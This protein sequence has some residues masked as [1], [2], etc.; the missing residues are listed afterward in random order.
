MLVTA[1]HGR[2]YHLQG[3]RQHGNVQVAVNGIRLAV[4]VKE[5]RGCAGDDDLIA[6]IIANVRHAIDRAVEQIRQIAQDGDFVRLVDNANVELAV[7]IKRLRGDHRAVAV[8]AGVG[9]RDQ[10][11]RQLHLLFLEA[12]PERRRLVSDQF[13]DA[14][15]E[16][17]Q[18][19]SPGDGVEQFADGRIEPDAGDHEEVAMPGAAGIHAPALAAGG[20][21][22]GPLGIEGNAE[23]ARQ[24]VARANRNDAERRIGS[25]QAR[26]DFVHR[27]VAADRYHGV[28]AVMRRG[29]GDF[30]RVAATGGFLDIH[31]KFAGEPLQALDDM[32]LVAPKP[33]NRVDD[34]FDFRCHAGKYKKIRGILKK[35][36][37]LQKKVGI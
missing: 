36:L 29:R 8:L 37:W 20:D 6:A 4:N 9:H 13:L 27:A 33:G 1:T 15:I 12:E 24:A 11:R 3:L 19:P 25:H 35:L 2:N 30:L 5:Q 22:D 21:R 17:R 18:R 14:Q 16:I 23:A 31:L 34:E 32:L 26:G 28:E 7:V 10:K